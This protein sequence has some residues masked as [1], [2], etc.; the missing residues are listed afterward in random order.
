MDVSNCVQLQFGSESSL[1]HVNY[2]T[3]PFHF[4]AVY[5]LVFIQNK[6][7]NS[8]GNPY[9]KVEKIAL[10]FFEGE[11]RQE[12]SIRYTIVNCSSS[13]LDTMLPT[14]NS[15]LYFEFYVS[16]RHFGYNKV[17]CTP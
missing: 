17:T 8:N 5:C 6:E 13:G 9:S 15:D 3:Y 1:L 10:K 4:L 7:K 16:I 14:N 2:R 11:F 12:R